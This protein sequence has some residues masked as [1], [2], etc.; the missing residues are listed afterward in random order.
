MSVVRSRLE[1]EMDKLALALTSSLEHDVNIFYYDILV[2]LAHVLTLL[3]AGHIT[4]REAREILKVI[5]EVREEGMPKEGEDVH[6]AI[7]ARIIEKVGSA[8]MKMHTARSRNDEVATCLRLF[9]RD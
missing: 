4:R 3:K 5:I 1:K 9:A 2:D 6:E 8:G 7:E